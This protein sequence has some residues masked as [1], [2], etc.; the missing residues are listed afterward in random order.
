MFLQRAENKTGAI[1]PVPRLISVTKYT[2][3]IPSF[4]SCL[5]A[6]VKSDAAYILQDSA[7][8]KSLK[9]YF[10]KSLICSKTYEIDKSY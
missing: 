4:G 6:L 3:E 1:S 8:H 2:L 7:F 9:N 5:L 10:P